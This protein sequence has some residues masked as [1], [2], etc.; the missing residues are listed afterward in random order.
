MIDPARLS[1]FDRMAVRLV[2]S[3]MG[4][5]RDWDRITAWADALTPR[6]A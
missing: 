1:F 4:D 2:K 5:R 6:L 3:P